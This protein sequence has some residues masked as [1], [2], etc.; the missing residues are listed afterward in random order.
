MT[1]A[2]S[3]NAQA[4]ASL[5]TGL[6]KAMTDAQEELSEAPPTDAFGRS[7]PSYQIPHLDFNFEIET[8]RKDQSDSPFARFAII[9]T[10]KASAQH[11]TV[12]SSI[13]GRIVAIPPHGGLPET[14]IVV[15][16]TKTTLDVQLLNTAGELLPNTLVEL[17]FD[18][19]SSLA[20]HNT[21][22][23]PAKRRGLFEAQQVATDDTGSVSA[24]IK[25]S[26]LATGQKA[27]VLLRAAGSETRV[28]IE[29]EG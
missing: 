9:P 6:A 10:G 21:T 27:V 8:T 1:D 25:R 28:T 18:P 22:L 3:T 4:I 7:L 14:R 5:L 2:A 19:D 26:Q 16:Q 15:T 12:S 24:K 17:E 23:T 13:S 20:L 11:N 29:R